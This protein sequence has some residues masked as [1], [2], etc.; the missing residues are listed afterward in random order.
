MH[1][2]S[3]GFK[4]SRTKLGNLISGDVRVNWSTVTKN[5][6]P[7]KTGDIVSVSGLGRNTDREINETRKGKFAIEIIK[8]K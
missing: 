7:L 4:I 6:F 2:A 1:V 8:F 3:A 5:G